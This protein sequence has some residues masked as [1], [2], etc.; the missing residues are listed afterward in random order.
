MLSAKSIM[1]NGP[2]R[3]AIIFSFIFSLS[4]SVVY[5]QDNSPYSRYGLGNLMALSNTASRGMGGISAA[6]LDYTGINFSNPA[7]YAAFLSAKERRTNKLESGRA[8]LDVG[9]NITNR[10]LIAPNTPNRFTSSDLLFFTVL[11]RMKD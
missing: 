1:L 8:I 4:V 11:K 2:R 5:A 3:F 9:I 7:S 6:Y 10:S